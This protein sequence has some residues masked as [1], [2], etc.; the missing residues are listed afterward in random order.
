MQS[1]RTL[2][3]WGH[4]TYSIYH[5]IPFLKGS[6][7]KTDVQL[8]REFQIQ[9]SKK[10]SE[11]VTTSPQPPEMCAGPRGNKPHT[12]NVPC[13]FG[14]LPFHIFFFPPVSFAHMSCSFLSATRPWL[15]FPLST[16]IFHVTRQ[17]ESR[18]ALK[19]IRW[20]LDHYHTFC[21][22]GF[23]MVLGYSHGHRLQQQNTSLTKTHQGFTW[24][25]GTYSTFIRPKVL[26]HNTQNT[27]VQLSIGTVHSLWMLFCLTVSEG[28]I[29]AGGSFEIFHVWFMNDTFL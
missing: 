16:H 21:F 1:C 11:R 18:S 14:F 4:R 20:L 24:R 12:S 17:V 5:F 27:H 8:L 28:F 9:Q 7:W 10:S 2:S 13:F 3:P 25:V 26:M 23:S 6:Q 15:T 29:R 19:S 22:E